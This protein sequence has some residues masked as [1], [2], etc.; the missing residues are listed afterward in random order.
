M[1]TQ[2]VLQDRA[3]ATKWGIRIDAGELLLVAVGEAAQAEPVLQDT[4]TGGHWQLFVDDGELGFETDV[5][6]STGQLF[7]EDSTTA[8]AVWEIQIE[9]GQLHFLPGALP[10]AVEGGGGR[11]RK[12]R[13][14]RRPVDAP[15]RLAQEAPAYERQQLTPS[16]IAFLRQVYS[17]SRETPDGVEPPAPPLLEAASLVDAE[18]EAEAEARRA[19][20]ALDR[21][22]L[23]TG[24]LSHMLEGAQLLVLQER[25]R[26]RQQQQQQEEEMLV[27][28]VLCALE[29]L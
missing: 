27:F 8:G 20:E 15:D 5:G 4:V 2:Y 1:A 19:E 26:V 12:R 18:A 3:L 13:R 16:E 23:Q 11:I 25:Q 10:V 6:P 21:L 9:D 14:A 22:E 7:I 17:P 29:A 24:V 28:A